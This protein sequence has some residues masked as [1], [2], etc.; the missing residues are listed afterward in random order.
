MASKQHA[1]VIGAGVIGLTTSI[2][3]QMSGRFKVTI[4]SKS[5]PDPKHYNNDPYYASREAGAHWCSFAAAEDKRL[6]E[7]EMVTFKTFMELAQYPE[8]GVKTM[9]S[10]CLSKHGAEEYEEPWYLP[11]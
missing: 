1:V 11:L 3:L 5:S 10:I 9:K 7:F 4:V 2:L 8:T 6:Q